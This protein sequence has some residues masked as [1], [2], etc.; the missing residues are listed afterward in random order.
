MAKPAQTAYSNTYLYL[1]LG[2][3]FLKSDLNHLYCKVV[4]FEVCSS[5]PFKAINLQHSTEWLLPKF[6]TKK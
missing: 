2:T 4:N 5:D 3:C 1:I 6:I